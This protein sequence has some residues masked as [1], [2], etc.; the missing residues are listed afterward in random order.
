MMRM[1]RAIVIGI[2]VALAPN[3]LRA[4]QIRP[5][6]PAFDVTDYV[7]AIDVPDT[8][9]PRRARAPLP[10]PRP[11]PADTLVL[12]LLDLTVNTVT[13]DGRAVRFDRRPSTI[14]IPLPR[15]S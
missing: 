14:V 1:R 5:Y 7:I 11:A 4:Q 15:K 12:D 9:P 6:Q 13:V 2:A 3:A 10:V 8:G